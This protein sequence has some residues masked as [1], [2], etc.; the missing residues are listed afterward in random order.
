MTDEDYMYLLT[1]ILDCGS[2]DIVKLNEIVDACEDVIPKNENYF[3]DI[4]KE[5]QYD[6]TPLNC[7]TLIFYLLD[8]LSQQLAIDIQKEF[9]LDD[10]DPQNEFEIEANY[11]CSSITYLGNKIEI[12]YYLEDICPFVDFA[13]PID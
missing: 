11:M 1:S 9:D 13:H 8:K 4:L 2:Q 6:S 5:M 12:I 10:F 7:N 3:Q